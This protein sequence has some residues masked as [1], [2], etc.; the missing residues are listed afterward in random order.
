MERK[1]IFTDLNDDETLDDKQWLNDKVSIAIQ[2]MALSHPSEISQSCWYA[3]YE[4]ESDCVKH[5]NRKVIV[6]NSFFS[7][8]LHVLCTGYEGVQWY[9]FKS[10]YKPMT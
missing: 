1:R 10:T 4:Q 7:E 3:A 5:T 6:L 8:K 2:C 9:Y